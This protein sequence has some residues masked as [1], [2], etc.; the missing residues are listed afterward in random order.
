MDTSS[1]I[2]CLK[3]EKGIRSNEAHQKPAPFPDL[4]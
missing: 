3:E 4:R 1:S 2:G